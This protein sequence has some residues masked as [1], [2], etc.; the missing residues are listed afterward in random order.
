MLGIPF[1]GH[2]DLA[3]LLLDEQ[4][5]DFPLR[6]DFKP[7]E[8]ASYAANLLRERHEQAMLAAVGAGNAGATPASP[9]MPQ[10]IGGAGG[11][12]RDSGNE[13]GHSGP[14]HQ[15]PGGSA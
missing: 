8:R 5:S 7:P 4:F 2:D 3:P 14:P 11:P 12:A 6:R 9:A 10:S 13:G 15:Q 1:S